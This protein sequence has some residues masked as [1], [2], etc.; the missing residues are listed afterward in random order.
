MGRGGCP[1][2]WQ[3]GLARPSLLEHLLASAPLTCL[4]SVS[5][6]LRVLT[7]CEEGYTGGSLWV[8][9]W[10][11]RGSTSNLTFFHPPHLLFPISAIFFLKKPELQKKN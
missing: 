8:P 3:L 1:A 4:T 6:W 9:E 5:A 10:Q 11:Q 2:L 7:E